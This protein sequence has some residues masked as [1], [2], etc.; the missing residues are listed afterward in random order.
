MTKRWYR[1]ALAAVL[2]VVMLAATA[3]AISTGGATT[4]TAVNFRTGPSTGYSIISTLP[5]GAKVVVSSE[6]GNGWSKVVYN[7]TTG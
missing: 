3:G 7:G 4:T 2:C 5:A 1:T 6:S